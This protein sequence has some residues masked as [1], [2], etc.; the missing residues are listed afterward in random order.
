M[1]TNLSKTTAPNPRNAIKAG[2]GYQYDSDFTY[3]QELDPITGLPVYY[4][5]VGV[6][7]SPTNQTKNAVANPTNEA[8]S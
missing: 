2:Q 3:D 6:T 8:K 1:A 5:A 7:P 4:D